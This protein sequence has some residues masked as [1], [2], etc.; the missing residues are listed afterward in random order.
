[1]LRLI[2]FQLGS[3]VSYDELGK[4]LGMSRN[5][6]ERYL[7]LLEKVFVIYRLGAFARNL[8][9][10]VTKAGKWYF[11]DNGIRNAITGVFSPLAV[12]S[13][14]DALWENYILNERRK[15]SLNRRWHTDFYFWRTYDKQE[16]DLVAESGGVLSAFEIKW[17]REKAS[18]SKAFEKAYPDVDF[19]VIHRENYLEFIDYNR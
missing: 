11:Y 3:E 9:K 4:Q 10:E 2:A 17:G 7:D 1:L 18:L 19:K 12:R 13:D 15:V 14:L 6:V 16:I 8:R 5:T